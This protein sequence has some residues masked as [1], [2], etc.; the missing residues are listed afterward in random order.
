MIRVVLMDFGIDDN[1]GN[2]T[3]ASAS[4]LKTIHVRCRL[5]PG[6]VSSFLG[7]FERPESVIQ[8]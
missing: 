1:I 8:Y 4:G 6:Q 3:K 7:G 2:I 5:D